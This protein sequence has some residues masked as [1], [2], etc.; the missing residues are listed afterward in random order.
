MDLTVQKG[1]SH[2]PVKAQNQQEPTRKT[3]PSTLSD[4]LLGP[5]ITWTTLF[6]VAAR[7]AQKISSGTSQ[8][9][10][11]RKAFMADWLADWQ[12]LEGCDQ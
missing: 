5:A 2:K 11:V 7:A 8:G 9:P 10:Q 12:R 3:A 1:M 6:P 4:V